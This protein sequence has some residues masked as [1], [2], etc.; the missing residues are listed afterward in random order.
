M[1]DFEDLD[2]GEYVYPVVNGRAPD[3]TLTPWR[4]AR[5]SR[6]ADGAPIIA[7]V[8]GEYDSE[9][10]GEFWMT[11]VQYL[12]DRKTGTWRLMGK[13]AG[14]LDVQWLPIALLPDYDK[15]YREASW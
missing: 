5:R 8:V 10:I 7:S 4:Y 9:G 15:R 6:G 1:L 2:L 11:Y 12:R 13:R 3:L 14:S